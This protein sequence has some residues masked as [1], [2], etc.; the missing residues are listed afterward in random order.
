MIALLRK[1]IVQ[2]FWL[3]LFSLMLAVLIWVTVSFVIQ[4]GASPA[5]PLAV[6]AEMRTFLNLPVGIMSS[7]ADVRNFKV[8][9]Q[10]VEVTVQG[11]AGVLQKLRSA[12][13]RVL[14]DLTGIEAAADLRKRVEVSTPAGIALVRV[15][16]QEVNI[17]YPSAHIPRS[18]P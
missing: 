10:Q 14:V 1:L 12:D 11:D 18:K 4:R 17:I 6:V 3:K 2:D 8:A 15:T 13:I 9:P 5:T 16:P 7:A